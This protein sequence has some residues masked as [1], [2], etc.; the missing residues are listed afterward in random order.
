MSQ[1]KIAEQ[2]LHQ[3]CWH[4]LKQSQNKSCLLTVSTESDHRLKKGGGI[5]NVVY[6]R[7]R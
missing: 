2:S 4:L 3:E 5:G 1:M 7:I 6:Y